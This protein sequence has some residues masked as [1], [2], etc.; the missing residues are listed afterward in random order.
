MSNLTE[1]Q[2]EVL[3]FIR[4]F[5]AAEG[6]PPTRAEIASALGFR[7]VNAAED[8]I[9][10]LVRKGALEV[11]PGLSRG[12][13]VIEQALAGA[14]ADGVEGEEGLPVVGRVAAG[15]PILALEHRLGHY[16]IDPE[17]F[18]PRAHYLLQVRGASMRDAGILDGDLLAV[19]RRREAENGQIVVARVDDE[20]TVKRFRQ[21]GNV[22]RLLP[23]NPDFEPIVVDLRRQSLVIEGIGVGVLRNHPL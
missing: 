16:R 18:R 9:R 6:L 22:V 5:T 19:H 10:A 20:V 23:E 7:S 1:R 15:S 17:L 11:R 3:E 13:R 12:L 2:R 21:R 8:H 14:L 4:R